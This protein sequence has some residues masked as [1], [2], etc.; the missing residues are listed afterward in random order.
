MNTKEKWLLAKMVDLLH[1]IVDKNLFLLLKLVNERILKE[2]KL[3]NEIEQPFFDALIFSSDLD[4]RET[5]EQILTFATSLMFD[6]LDYPRSL[7]F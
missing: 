1:Q 2:V 3:K 5:M 4:V 6:C 7:D